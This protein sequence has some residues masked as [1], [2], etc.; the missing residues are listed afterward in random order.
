MTVNTPV[1]T[2]SAVAFGV[3]GYR[4]LWLNAFFTAATFTVETLSQG[5]LVLLLTNSP[6][7]VGLAAGARGASQAV[8]S[9]PA[10]PQRQCVSVDGRGSLQDLWRAG[11]RAHHR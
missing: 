2:G 1:Q 7:W 6:F 5:W 8:F 9:I 11:R 3:P 10:A 4:W